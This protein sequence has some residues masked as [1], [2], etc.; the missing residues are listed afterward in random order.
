MKTEPT[1]ESEPQSTPTTP[2][3]PPTVPETAPSTSEIPPSDIP[4]SPET[5]SEPPTTPPYSLLEFV[6]TS[7]TSS[8][9]DENEDPC[10]RVLATPPFTAWPDYD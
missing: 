4:A 8:I 2:E 6:R 9:P 7:P 3:T 5:P 1:T 10:T